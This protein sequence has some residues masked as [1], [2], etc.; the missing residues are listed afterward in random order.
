MTKKELKKEIKMWLDDFT[1]TEE[2][3][4]D[5]SIDIKNDAFDLLTIIYEKNL[6]K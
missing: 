6:I 1:K 5:F 4:N 2:H 3:T